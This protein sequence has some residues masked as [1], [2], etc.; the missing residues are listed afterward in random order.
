MQSL[1]LYRATVSTHFFDHLLMKRINFP[2]PSDLLGYSQ[3]PCK[4]EL[5]FCRKGLSEILEIPYIHVVG[6]QMGVILRSNINK[7]LLFYCPAITKP[8]DVKNRGSPFH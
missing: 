6:E 8:V 7:G 5:A 2:G 1:F 3:V 4:M